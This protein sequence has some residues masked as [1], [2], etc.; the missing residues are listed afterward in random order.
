MDTSPPCLWSASAIIGLGY[1]SDS[2]IMKKRTIEIGALDSLYT[3]HGLISSSH[4][5]CKI[6]YAF[7]FQ[8]LQCDKGSP[9]QIDSL[10]E[11]PELMQSQSAR[12]IGPPSKQHR[13]SKN[14]EKVS[15]K[16]MI[17]L[18]MCLYHGYPCEFYQKLAHILFK[19]NFS[20]ILLGDEVFFL[21]N[22]LNMITVKRVFITSKHYSLN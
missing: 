16:L 12:G 15:T 1:F 7:F 5:T 14:R 10:S 8:F 4:S 21:N 19:K 9:P 2:V 11:F 18:L 6:S 3:W 13:P 22:F 20:T 17:I